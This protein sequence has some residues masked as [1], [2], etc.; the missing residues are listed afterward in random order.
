MFQS[1][2][3]GSTWSHAEKGLSGYTTN[4]VVAHPTEGSTATT[5]SYGKVFRTDD[6]GADWPLLADTGFAMICLSQDQSNPETLFAG[7]AFPDF[8]ADGVLKSVDGGATWNPATNGLSVNTLHRLAISPSGSE[9]V[10]AASVDGLSQSVDGGDL[11][12]PV[13]STEDVRCS[14]YDPTDASILYAGAAYGSLLRSADGGSIWNA[15][16]GIPAPAVNNWDLAAPSNDPSRV[17]LATSTGIYRSIDRGLDFAAA[18]TGLPSAPGTQPYRL[19]ADPSRAGTLYMLAIFGGGAATDAP[20]QTAQPNVF[21]TTNGADSW[22]ALPGLLP[23]LGS[24]ELSVSST[25]RTL[26]AA[27]TSGTFQ[28]DRSFLD[29]ADADPFWPSVDA[30]AMNGVTA[31]CGGGRFCPDDATLRSSIAVFLLRAKNGASY[32]PPPATGTVFGDVSADAPAAPYIEELFHEGITAG[33][34]GG[35]YCPDAPVSRAEAAVLL[36]KMEHGSDFVPPHATGLVFGDVAADA[37]AADWIE[38]LALEGLTAGCG[39]GNFCPD[40][41]VSRAQAAAFVTRAF[42]LS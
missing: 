13:L 19:A 9:H 21:R 1:L 18:N 23:S 38:Q 27:T 29:V 16:S 36:L 20:Q 3:G 4:G 32:A 14:A 41:A 25:G 7:Y 34:G 12:T 10:L 8:S 42:G 15:P 37:F 11:W 28:F 39:S 2:D 30:A 6:S 35:E 33:C 24:Y 17:Y 31:G 5:F 40:A 22:T 26:Y